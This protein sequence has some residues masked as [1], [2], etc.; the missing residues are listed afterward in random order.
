[1]TRQQHID[2]AT[3]AAN[4]AA[5]LAE[6]TDKAAHHADQRAIVSNLAAA[7]TAWANAARAHAAIAAV[8]AETNGEK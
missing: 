1:M 7:S 3:T 2:Q 6:E 5:A 4:R 8:M